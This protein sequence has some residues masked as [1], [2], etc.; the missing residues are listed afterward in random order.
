MRSSYRI[1]CFTSLFY[2]D[3]VVLIFP[4]QSSIDIISMTCLP[5][6]LVRTSQCFK[7]YGLKIL[8]HLSLKKIYFTLYIVST[9]NKL[10]MS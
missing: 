7:I 8:F 5:F 2:F 3:F 10:N 1:L 6:G 9:F 4:K